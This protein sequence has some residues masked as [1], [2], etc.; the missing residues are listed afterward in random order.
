MTFAETVHVNQCIKYL[1][2]KDR[3]R[4]SSRAETNKE[5]GGELCVDDVLVDG[6]NP[7][8]DVINGDAARGME[9]GQ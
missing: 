6:L 2:I 8:P 9:E 7:A 4:T 5:H 1:C 3:P